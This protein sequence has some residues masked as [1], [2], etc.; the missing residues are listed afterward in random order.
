M[1]PG[2][3]PAHYHAYWV[4]HGLFSEKNGDEENTQ[5]KPD[6]LRLENSPALPE[7][8]GS[9]EIIP[10]VPF[11]RSRPSLMTPP[12]LSIFIDFLLPELHFID[13]FLMHLFLQFQRFSLFGLLRLNLGQLMV[14][15][16]S[17]STKADLILDQ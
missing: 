3:A 12:V 10:D 4:M 8:S 5:K 11:Q 2:T 9:Q 17:G 13:V 16:L 15:G 1:K 7:R 14:Y 6:D